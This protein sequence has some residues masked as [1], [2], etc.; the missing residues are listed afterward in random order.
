M[1][2]LRA[3]WEL[4]RRGRTPEAARVVLTNR[5]PWM[6]WTWGW[7]GGAGVKF[8][9]WRLDGDLMVNDRSSAGGLCR[10]GTTTARAIKN[11]ALRDQPAEAHTH[12]SLPPSLPRSSLPPRPLASLPPIPIHLA[13]FLCLSEH[14]CARVCIR[15]CACACVC[16]HVWACMLLALPAPLQVLL[17]QHEGPL[18]WHMRV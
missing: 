9:G 16:M 4:S 5:S 11:C 12:F 13:T 10:V 14:V 8:E 1:S 17:G 3:R 2:S 6:A 18:T 15:A 7:W